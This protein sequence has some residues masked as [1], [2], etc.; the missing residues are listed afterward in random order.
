MISLKTYIHKKIVCPKQFK[1]VQ[2]G[3]QLSKMVQM[4]VRGG[5]ANERP[6]TD[7]VTSGPMRALKKLHPMSQNHTQ[8]DGHGDSMTESAQGGQFSENIET[9]V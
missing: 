1:M 2:H 4:L 6:R 8:T 7:H 9:L 5:G 3:P